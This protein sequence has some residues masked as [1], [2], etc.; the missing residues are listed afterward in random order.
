MIIFTS[1]SKFRSG[2]T[3]ASQSMASNIQ[4]SQNSC[5]TRF[6]NKFLQT[7]KCH[8]SSTSTIYDCS[9]TWK[10]IIESF[11][12]SVSK[13]FNFSKLKSQ[14]K[15]CQLDMIGLDVRD[16]FSISNFIGFTYHSF[17]QE[18]NNCAIRIS[19]ALRGTRWGSNLKD[20]N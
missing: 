13:D 1:W 17:G 19:I 3:R 11:L 12:K 15:Y 5:F 9:Y 8:R 2:T 4:K 18:W 6:T 16:F 20:Q 14:K 7:L 10:K